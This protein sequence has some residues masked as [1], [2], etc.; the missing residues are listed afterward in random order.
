L[1]YRLIQESSSESVFD[2][3]TRQLA[4]HGYIARGGQMIAVCIAQ[5]PRQSLEKE[6]KVI[7]SKGAMPADWKP[8][9]RRQKDMDARWTRKHGKSYLGYK[10]SAN[11]DKRYKLVRVRKAPCSMVAGCFPARTR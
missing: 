8:A 5:P 11:P 7:V 3:V 4:T 2:A 1:N 10:V 6:E 9:K